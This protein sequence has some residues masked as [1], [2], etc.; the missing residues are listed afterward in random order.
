[1]TEIAEKPPGQCLICGRPL[2]QADDP[3]SIDC[4][5]DCLGCIE[6]IEAQLTEAP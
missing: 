1:M 5:G 4:G 3:L 2:D 6:E